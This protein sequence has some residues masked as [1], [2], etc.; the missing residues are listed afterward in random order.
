MPSD[1]LLLERARQFDRQ[2]LAEIY[3]LYSPGLYRYAMRLLGDPQLAEECVAETFSRFL[4]ALKDGKGPRDFLQAYL[5]RVAHNWI[6]DLYR[7]EP[8][9]ETLEETHPDF[10]PNPETAA[11]ESL[12]DDHLLKA[13]RR[14]TPDQ[15]QVILLKFVEEWENEA[16][17]RALNKPVGAVKS[18]QHRALASLQRILNEETR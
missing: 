15:Q 11:E 13:I 7:R 5:Y 12:R 18:L 8:A 9:P 14:L 16:I 17:A 10:A 6:T 1:S 3:D 4:H 2:A